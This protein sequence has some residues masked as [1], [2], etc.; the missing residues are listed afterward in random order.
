MENPRPSLRYAWYV[1]AV[2]MIAYISS[3]VDRQVLT[4]LVKPL[5]RDFHITDTQYGLL[6]GLSFAIFYTFLGIPI[7]RLADRHSRKRIIVWGITIWSL[8]TA[9]CGMAGSYNQLFLARIGVGVGE[10]A[11]SPAAYSLITDLFPRHKLGTALAVY[12][13]GVYLGSGLS[14]LLVALVLKLISVD[15]LW[16]LPL[17]GNIFPWQ[18]VFFLVGLP[19]LL[20]VIL[21]ALTIR[22][23]H[24]AI[25]GTVAIPVADLLAYYRQN[26]RAILHLFFGIAFMAFSSYS[27]TAWVPT[28]LERK[29]DLTASQAGLLLGGIITVFSTAGV[30]FGGRYGDRLTKQ[31][32][33]D[34]K[35]RVGFVGM[36]FGATLGILLLAGFLFEIVS[37]PVLIGLLILLCFFTAMPFGSATAAMQEM[38]PASMRATFSALFLFVVNIIGLTGGPSMVGVLNDQLFHDDTQ[39]HLSLGI[40]IVFGTS[41]SALL[42]YRGLIPFASA[43]ENA[44]FVNSRIVIPEVP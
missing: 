5:K 28:L 16:T 18:S 22:E 34:A 23:P 30:L 44:R 11:L 33:Q 21:I 6:V 31:G 15:G 37:L 32:V 13:I 24:R 29:Y 1:V 8:M 40:A 41:L 20:I 10:A 39:V 17:I 2:L 3:F 38:V 42:L 35:M 43:V 26:Q 27:V 25:K 36:S 9:L 7:G 14:I 12:N 4:L 19:G